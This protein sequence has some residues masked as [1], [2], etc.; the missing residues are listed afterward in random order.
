MKRSILIPVVCCLFFPFLSFAQTDVFQGAWHMDYLPGD[1]KPV[2]MDLQIGPPEK[3]MLYPAELTIKCDSFSGT[4]NLLL[5]KRNIRQLAI[6]KNKIPSSE[7]PFSLGNWPIFL[8][9]ILDLTRDLKGVATLSV[10]RLFSKQYGVTMQ[11]PRDLS[12]PQRTTATR[13]RDLLKDAD[14]KLRKTNSSV[15]NNVFMD[16]V[17][18]TGAINNNYFGI[19]DTVQ[20]D[21]RK[22]SVNFNSNKKNNGVVSVILNGSIVV[23]QN[24]LSARKP[25]EDI[26]LDTGLN[27]FA[28][29]ADS[30]GK[31]IGTT[32]NIAVEFGEKKF[33][34]DFANKNDLAA[35]F[36]VAKIYYSPE[37]EKEKITEAQTAILKELS[38]TDL[39]RDI[40]L[41]HY[42]DLTGRNLIQNDSAKALANLALLR[43]SKPVGSLKTSSREVILALWDDAVQDGDSISLSINGHWVVQNFLV[44]KQPQFISVRIDPG[45]N[46]IIFVANNLGSIAPNTA[47]LEIIDGRQRKSFMLETDLTE[48]NSINILYDVKPD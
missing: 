43:N 32:G 22:G 16:T 31:T 41:F 25:I 45:A 29:F 6:G 11:D 23:D 28:F 21:E 33:T 44:K 1:S 3:S 24:D 38:Q 26:K 30:Y 10:E 42:P 19:Q 17:L 39:Q 13:L 34:L 4:Y 46:Q 40:K 2:T 20:V 15:V 18:I 35:T 12:A 27:I 14:I 5:V 9:G 37:K 8:N 48:N 7:S 36:I 47:I